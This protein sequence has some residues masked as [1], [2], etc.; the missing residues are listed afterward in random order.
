M[1][2]YEYNE[3]SLKLVAVLAYGNDLR[4]LSCVGCTKKDSLNCEM[5]TEKT[6]Q[7]YYFDPLNISINTCPMNC[8][9][10]EHF[11]FLDRYQYGNLPKYEDCPRWYWEMHK[12]FD[13]YK[14]IVE[15]KR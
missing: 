14:Q 13:V 5:S 4:G 2:E 8:I 15:A 10:P 1:Q 3:L 11:D 9:F 12:K 7:C 6:G